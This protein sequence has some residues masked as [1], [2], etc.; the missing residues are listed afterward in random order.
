MST[1]P[2]SSVYITSKWSP[3]IKNLNK[4]I[5]YYA[6][7]YVVCYPLFHDHHKLMTRWRIEVELI[8]N[9]IAETSSLYFN[10]SSYLIFLINISLSFSRLVHLNFQKNN[11]NYIFQSLLGLFFSSRSLFFFFSSLNSIWLCKMFIDRID[12][13]SSIACFLKKIRV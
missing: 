10:Y 7:T 12:A 1:N 13:T 9:S 3:T 11:F 2:T 4:N 6:K 5:L 8:M